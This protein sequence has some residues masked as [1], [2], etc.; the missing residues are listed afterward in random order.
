MQEN[1]V[2]KLESQ[3]TGKQ[4][5][6]AWL[7]RQEQL[8]GFVEC[9]I[10]NAE[11]NGASSV[12]LIIDDI[13]SGFILECVISCNIRALELREAHLEKGLLSLC[14]NRFL[15]TTGILAA[16]EIQAFRRALKVFV[17]KWMLFD[18]A[19]QIIRGEHFSG[20]RILFD[21][22][23]AMLD[24]DGQTAMDLCLI[25]NDEIAPAL[26]TERITH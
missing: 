21:D 2:A 13:D 20:L 25:F 18:R 9:L 26:G 5:V 7:H 1:R 11:M 17:L 22:T 8:G 12:P 14:L 16:W 3:L 10:R 19:V 24:K 15:H 6:L 4:R 23:A